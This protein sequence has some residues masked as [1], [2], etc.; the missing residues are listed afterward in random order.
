M[1]KESAI[2]KYL[3]ETVEKHSGLCIKLSPFGLRGIPDRLII[4]PGPVIV[5]AELKKPK[6]GVVARHQHHWR[7]RLTALGCTHVFLHTREDVATLI[8]ELTE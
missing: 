7:D 3:R 2:E 4:L 8:R 1:T 5:F 6:G